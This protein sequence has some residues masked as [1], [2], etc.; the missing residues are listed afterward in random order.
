[1]ARA[2]GWGEDQILFSGKSTPCHS[3]YGVCVIGLKVSFA[4]ASV[5]RYFLVRGEFLVEAHP[6]RGWNEE[7]HEGLWR[8]IR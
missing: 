3:V 6:V 1:M 7:F 2:R 8:P 4:V 5:K